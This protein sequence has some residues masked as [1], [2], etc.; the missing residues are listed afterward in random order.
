[1]PATGQEAQFPPLERRGLR[2]LPTVADRL[3]RPNLEKSMPVSRTSEPVRH[4]GRFTLYN[5]CLQ[6]SDDWLY[7]AYFPEAKSRDFADLWPPDAIVSE[8]TSTGFTG[9]EAERRHVHRERD[10][11]E[12]W[13]VV[14]STSGNH[15][16]CHYRTLRIRPACGA[17]NATSTIR[18]RPWRAPTICASL[19]CAGTDRRIAQIGQMIGEAIESL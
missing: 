9:V 7:C 1:M 2:V 4:A 11:A 6:V 17:S 12:L 8:M 13:S 18:R 16:C 10:L 15:N 3:V 5:M 19:R 14:G